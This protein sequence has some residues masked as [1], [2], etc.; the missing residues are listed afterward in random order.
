MAGP[1]NH[2][3]P[4]DNIDETVVVPDFGAMDRGALETMAAAAREVLDIH[5]CLS[6]TGDNVVG[7]LIKNAGTFY[8]WNHYPDGDV[9]D[10]RTGSQFFY[11][12]HPADLRLG[13]HGHFHTFLRPAG[14]PPEMMP[15]ALPDY[16]LP[17]KTEN[18]LSHIVAVSMDS[19]GIPICLFTT[20]RWVTGECWYDG[21]DVTRMIDLFEIGHT[22]PSWPVNR[23]VTAVVRMFR[24]HIAALI[25]ARDKTV[26]A[27]DQS[28]VAPEGIVFEDRALEVTSYCRISVE[29]HARAVEAALAGRGRARGRGVSGPTSRS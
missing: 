19:F 28:G 11:H 29:G 1:G 22:Q 7:E 12:A 6:R 20:N 16:A 24:P 8:E 26:A 5:R 18:A 17:E 10:D 15:M 4:A 9:Y 13:E 2:V 25:A 21:V 23:W 27:W 3:R 14:M